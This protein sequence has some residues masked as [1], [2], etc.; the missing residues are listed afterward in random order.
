MPRPLLARTVL[1][2]LLLALSTVVGVAGAAAGEYTLVQ[3]DPLHRG[4]AAASFDRGGDP[5]Y[6]IRRDCSSASGAAVKLDNVAAAPV[7]AEGRVSWTTPIGATV[8]GAAV[9]ARLRSHGGHRAR[10]RF[11]DADGEQA[12]IVATGAN[13]PATFRRY[14]ASLSGGGRHGFAAILTCTLADGCARS[15]NAHSWLRDIRLTVRDSSLPSL[16]LLGDIFSPGWLRGNRTLGYRAADAGSGLRRII[17][18]VNGVAVAPTRTLGCQTVGGAALV[19]AM[20]P[21]APART[22]AVVHPTAGARFRDG[23]NRVRVCAEDFGARANRRCLDR[24]VLIDNSAPRAAFRTP[25]GADPELIETDLSDPHSGIASARIAYRPVGG[26]E[27]RELPTRLE[28]DR[29]SARID[30]SSE[31]RGRYAF[32]IVS[33]DHAGNTAAAT[34]RGDGSPMI[35]EFPL[36]ERTR[37]SAN[38]RLRGHRYGSRPRLSGGV[39]RVDA[40]GSGWVAVAGAELEVVERFASGAEP[41]RAVHSVRTGADGRYETRLSAGPSRQVT[42]SYRGG[43]RMLPSASI[44]R[45]LVVAGRAGLR[46]SSKRVRA[47]RRIHFRGRIGMLGVARPAPGRVVELQAREAGSGRFRTVR[48][49][50][51]ADDRG[52]VRTSYRFRR[53]YRSRTR[54]QFR[55]KL[56]RQPLWPYG[57]PAHSRPWSL[58]VVPRRR[59]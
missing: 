46:A 30:S 54:F 44:P 58:T 35:L 48:Q 26:G 5:Y 51:H 1:T 40:D 59:R 10:L 50:L 41:Q 56:T 53:F 27:W 11:L 25:S 49:A 2:S 22:E 42:V 34:V 7:G 13:E 4:L 38:A 17:A 28:G 32:R 19:T 8:I 6:R 23:V 45:R 14:S 21:C 52:R 37:V 9:R 55:L 15:A 24:E 31:P 47:G 18:T 33:S 57:A 3:C 29:A 43:K 12:G 16:S 39:R 36:R 20:R